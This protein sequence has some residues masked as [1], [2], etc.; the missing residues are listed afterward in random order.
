[1]YT[2]GYVPSNLNGTEINAN[3]ACHEVH[4]PNKYQLDILDPIRD[5]GDTPKCVSICVTDMI[6]WKSREFNKDIN[7]SDDYIYNNCKCEGGVRPK[8]ALEFI[9]KG[10]FSQQFDINY[11]I[12]ATVPTVWAAKQCLYQFGP[13]M[14]CIPVRS[15]SEYF[16]YGNEV[17]A[18]QAVLIVGYDEDNLIF[19]NSWGTKWGDLGYGKLPCFDYSYIKEAW[20]IIR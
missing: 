12:Y 15:S 9:T 7:F 4:I 10:T 18:G 16:W 20:T 19:R 8:D 11:S 13:I 17:L 6:R 14:A 3:R 5:Q 1:M 2:Y